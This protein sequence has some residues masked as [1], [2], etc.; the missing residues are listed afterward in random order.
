[1]MAGFKVWE[2]LD[3]HPSLERPRATYYA[4]M[5]EAVRVATG[6]NARRFDGKMMKYSCE[7][8]CRIVITKQDL[9]QLLNAQG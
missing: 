6:L 5:N 1:M 9:L 2:V 3:F 4:T 7:I 8:Y